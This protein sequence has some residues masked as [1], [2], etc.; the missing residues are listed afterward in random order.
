MKHDVFA[1]WLKV[2]IAG[3]TMIGLT[4]CAYV[5]PQAGKILAGRYPEYSYWLLP[6]E[7]VLWI[8]SVPVFVAMVI[9]WVIASNI[10]KDNS[11]TGTNAKL[12]KIFSLL[13]LGDSIFFLLASIVFWIIGMNE[14]GLLFIDLLIVF[15]G[16]AIFVC[17]SAISYLVDKAARLQEDSD[18]TI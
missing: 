14:A 9:A 11:F 15:I 18:L 7:I 2:V 5:I 16:L 6:W 17:T 1:K 12:F 13:A 3:T 4:C 10:E 8:T